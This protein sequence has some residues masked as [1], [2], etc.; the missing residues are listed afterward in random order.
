QR[1]PKLQGT[2]PS[3]EFHGLFEKREAF[4]GVSREL[5][6]VVSGIG[7]GATS[8]VDIA[9]QK[10]AAVQRLVKPFV[11]VQRERI[12]FRKSYE[13]FRRRQKSQGSVGAVDVEPGIVRL[14]DR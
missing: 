7:E 4:D 2:K 6:G 8:N 13:L 1:Q 3:G 5:F 10:A 9:M 12:R 11:R 14:R